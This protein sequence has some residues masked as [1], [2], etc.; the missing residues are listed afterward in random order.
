MTGLV[1]PARKGE[2]KSGEYLRL[3]FCEQLR[4]AATSSRR[5]WRWFG[6]GK[7]DFTSFRIL[8]STLKKRAVMSRAM[9]AQTEKIIE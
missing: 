8:T 9:S 5:C 6:A 3:I 1:R 2:V 7:E 4:S